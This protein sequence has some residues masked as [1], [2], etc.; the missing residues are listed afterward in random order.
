MRNPLDSLSP[1]VEK[2]VLATLTLGGYTLY[3]P[4][5][6][7]TKTLTPHEPAL[8]IDHATPLVPAF[9]YIYAFVFLAGALPVTVPTGR[10]LFRRIC[11][12][13]LLAEIVS[14]VV[15]IAWPVSMTIRP[16]APEVTSLATW[17][18]AMAYFVDESSN[19][20]PSLHVSVALFAGL[21]TWTADRTVGAMGIAVALA[22]SASTMFVKQHWFLD[23]VAGVVLA[24][25]AWALLV[26][27]VERDP[28][29][30]DRRLVWVMTGGQAALYGAAALLYASGWAP[31][32]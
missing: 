16:E 7:Y 8:A 24:V 30:H 20:L 5:G 23:V 32:E 28:G 21:C 29:P 10:R 22:I 6:Q 31:W 17:G 4:I 15:F 12:A 2:I 14:Y 19:C 13:Y 25:G 9:I 18:I 26:R 11:A 3:W 27:G 1:R